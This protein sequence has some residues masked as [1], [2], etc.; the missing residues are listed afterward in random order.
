LPANIRLGFK[1]VLDNHY[2]TELITGAKFYDKGYRL[3]K[4][5]IIDGILKTIFCDYD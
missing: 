2:G 3:A 4:C 5:V 1:L